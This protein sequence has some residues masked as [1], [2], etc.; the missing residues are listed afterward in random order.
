MNTS[1][2]G[3]LEVS[4]VGLGC[5]NFGGRID[6]DQT[7]T[8]VD[9]A[10]EHG[11]TYFDTAEL[12]TDGRSEQLL[13]AAL[14]ARRDQAVIA[15]K[16]G[17]THTIAKGAGRP[18]Q[19]RTRLEAS[20]RRLGTDRVDHFQLHRPDPATPV[21]ETL[22]C[23][24]ELRDEGKILEI[25]CSAFSAAQLRE[26][27]AAAAADGVASWASVQNH[28]SVLTREPER[29]GVLD[30]C[31]ELDV[32]FV[33]YFPLEAGLLT[34][35][36]RAGIDRPQGSRLEQMGDRSVSFIDDDRLAIVEQ[37]VVW[38]EARDRS[39]LELAISWHTSHPRIASVIAGA[40]TPEQIAGNVHA[41]G[42]QMTA[43]DRA[44]V[45]AILARA[46][47]VGDALI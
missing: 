34:G 16:W 20:L 32:A 46:E 31:A 26:S 18:D 36:Y 7:Q 19:I 40:T 45:D 35:K 1:R 39:M 28:Y 25:G 10:L 33:P 44:E 14:G 23:L 29:D 11:I 27:A 37:L 3:Q 17:H 4:V 15:T 43:A 6:A 22:G 21:A 5:N 12:Y 9:A 8:V 13:G 30:A 41:A 24:A 2:I 47:Y 42:W 38:C